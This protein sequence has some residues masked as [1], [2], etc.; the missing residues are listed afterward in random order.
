MATEQLNIG[1]FHYK[2]GGTDGVSL[3]IDKWKQV[4]EEMGHRVHL[5]AG[6]LGNV[7]GTLIPEL[8]HHLAA[9]E[10]L[11]HNTFCELRDFDTQA[12]QRELNRWALELERILRNSILRQGI[13]FILAQN[14][15]SV[16]ASPPVAI[17]LERVR[18]SLGL[19]T[20]AHN[21][22]FYWERTDGVALTSAAAVELA[23]KYLPPRD[24]RITHVVINSLAQRELAER[25]GVQA[26]IVPNVFEFESPGW[27]RDDYNQDFRE[28]IGLGPNDLLILQATRIVPRKGIELA[29]DFVKALNAPARRALLQER[30][31]YDGRPFTQESRIVLVLAGY[32]QD[33]VTGLYPAKLRRKAER[34]GV[35]ALFI[36]E[37]VASRR[38]H[39]DGHKLYS[40]WDTYVFADL[41][42][43]PSLWEGWGNQLLE[44]IYARV[45]VMLFEY[46][47][48]QADIKEK[49]LR[50]ISLGNQIQGRDEEGLVQVAQETVE[51]AADQAVDLL[52]RG[53]LRRDVVEHNFGVGLQHYSMKALRGYLAPLFQGNGHANGQVKGRMNG[54]GVTR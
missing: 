35:E 51:R 24:P 29:I 14:V 9:H 23:D 7:D 33:D 22:D 21:H 17:A 42:T 37:Q 26:R 18:R 44:A 11:Y 47:V 54:S 53:E 45:P 13:N 28:R 15:W 46:P 5:Y 1:V 6:D 10:R 52:T 38:Q 39:R 49:G 4:L 34:E 12:Y 32:A 36:E 31:L 40:L 2:V 3:E 8:Y 19:P 27:G 43:Y 50:V 41:V 16:A 30:G 20:V 25:K 48:Y